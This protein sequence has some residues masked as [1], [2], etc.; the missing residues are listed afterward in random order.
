MDDDLWLNI[1]L[2]SGDQGLG[3]GPA[4]HVCGREEEA[5]YPPRP[6]LRRLRRRGQDPGRRRP[7]LR[8]GARGHSE[9]ERTL[10]RVE[11]IKLPFRLFYSHHMI[12]ITFGFVLSAVLCCAN[13]KTFLL[14]VVLFHFV[15]IHF[16][17][18]EEAEVMTWRKLPGLL[19]RDKQPRSHI[20]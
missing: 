1:H 15:S 11:I 6:R 13:T 19:A 17:L 8:G 4:G 20:R 9:E 5:G 2:C 18:Q 3:P 12:M 16:I 14:L 7:R 10:D